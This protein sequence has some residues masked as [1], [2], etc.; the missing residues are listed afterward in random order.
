MIELILKKDKFKEGKMNPC[1]INIFGK[2][3]KAFYEEIPILD[4]SRKVCKKRKI[5]VLNV[6]TENDAELLHHLATNM[7][8][9]INVNG[10]CIEF[11][12][13]FSF[14]RDYTNTGNEGYVK[15]LTFIEY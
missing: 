3:Y 14:E 6:F 12:A 8:M 4:D 15:N 7:R 9:A 2:E 10:K 1:K 11:Y 13:H 5:S